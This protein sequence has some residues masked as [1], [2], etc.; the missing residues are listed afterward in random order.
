MELFELF[1]DHTTEVVQRRSQADGET[2]PLY[3]ASF[4]SDTS[5]DDEN[6]SKPKTVL[7]LRMLFQL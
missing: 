6:D 3:D 7:D 4:N 2:R 5:S 1:G